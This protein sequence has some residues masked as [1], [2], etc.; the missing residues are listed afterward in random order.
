MNSNTNVLYVHVCHVSCN[1]VVMFACALVRSHPDSRR[2]W[3]ETL[4]A[5]INSKIPGWAWQQD[6]CFWGEARVG[7]SLS[8]ERG[9]KGR[10]REVPKEDR[11]SIMYNN[12]YLVIV[13]SSIYMSYHHPCI[14]ETNTRY[15]LLF[16]FP[17]VKNKPWH[18]WVY[19]WF[20]HR[21]K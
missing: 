13:S 14:R 11:C 3:G 1:V 20:W 7:L 4:T 18:T 19:T 16:I 2:R 8:P 12:I 5:G 6:A 17:Q 10:I 15:W 21:R 9:H